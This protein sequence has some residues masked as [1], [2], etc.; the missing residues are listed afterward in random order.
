MEACLFLLD[1]KRELYKLPDE[2]HRPIQQ[3]PAILKVLLNVISTW[4]DAGRFLGPYAPWQSEF[5]P[6]R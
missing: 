6:P 5:F 1:G 2:T 3:E 4:L